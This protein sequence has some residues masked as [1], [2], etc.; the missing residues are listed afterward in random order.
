M[1]HG[2]PW[3]IGYKMNSSQSELD[4]P[5]QTECE[6]SDNKGTSPSRSLQVAPDRPGPK[7]EQNGKDLENF[8]DVFVHVVCMFIHLWSTVT[9]TLHWSTGL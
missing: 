4:R 3:E 7:E 6:G 1:E 2:A 5:G 8:G 9:T